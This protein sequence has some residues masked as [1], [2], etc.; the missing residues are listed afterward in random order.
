MTQ[1]WRHTRRRRKLSELLLFVVGFVAGHRVLSGRQFWV[2]DATTSEESKEII[3]SVLRAV[4]LVIFQCDIKV[5][6]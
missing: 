3:N 1:S 2:E 6:T 4:F 5:R